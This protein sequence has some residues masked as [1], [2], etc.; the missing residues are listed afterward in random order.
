ML[1]IVLVTGFGIFLVVPRETRVVK[2]GQALKQNS[3]K[4][5]TTVRSMYIAV[6][7]G[8]RSA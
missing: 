2:A 3:L 1:I 5:R 8:S 4:V 7:E 6:D